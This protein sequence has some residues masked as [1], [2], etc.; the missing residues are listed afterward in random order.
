M[1]TLLNPKLI[2]KTPKLQAHQFPFPKFPSVKLF[3]KLLEEVGNFS[4]PHP[5]KYPLDLKA[6]HLH[7]LP[8]PCEMV[9]P[10]SHFLGKEI[11]S[12]HHQFH[13]APVK[14]ASG[15]SILLPVLVLVNNVDLFK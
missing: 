6:S 1:K 3:P 10:L 12:L 15:L 8:K 4:L 9:N 13:N 2:P 7:P 5:I 14:A 11:D